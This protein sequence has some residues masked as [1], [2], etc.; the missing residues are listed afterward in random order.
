MADSTVSGPVFSTR[1]RNGLSRLIDPPITASPGARVS[2]RLSPVS[3]DSSTLLRPSTITP[4]AGMDSPGRTRTRS[5]GF[6]SATG[7][8]VSII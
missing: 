8:S 4:S 6:S 1:I 7:T 5:P 2:G 3:S